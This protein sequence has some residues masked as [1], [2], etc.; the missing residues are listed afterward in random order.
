V[1]RKFLVLSLIA[2]T[3]LAISLAA[4]QPGM[5]GSEE[6]LVTQQGWE[7]EGSPEGTPQSSAVTKETDPDVIQSQWEASPHAHTYVLDSLGM[8]SGCARCHA[9]TSFVPSMDEMPES[10]AV[11]KFE[12]APPPP[13]IAEENW[14]NVTCNICHRMKKDEVQPGYAWLSVPPIDEY[15]DLATTSELCLKCH[16]EVEIIGHG[17]PNLASAHSSYTCTQCHDAHSTK[18]SCTSELCHTSVADSTVPIT[19]HDVDHENV[20]CWACHDGD[21]MIVKPGDQGRWLTYLPDSEVAYASHNILK[22]VS[23]D[24]CHFVNNVWGLS[25][26]VS[27][28]SP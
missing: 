27:Q 10:C 25:D 17:M 4:C 7:N 28:T 24:R 21:A 23:C 11:C 26:S 19:G 8:N 20:T 15:E 14:G 1:Q 12:V 6:T 5:D 22:Q 3:V 13:T 2:I 18:A 9:P 16:G